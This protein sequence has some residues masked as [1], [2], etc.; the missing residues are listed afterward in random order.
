MK[1]DKNV[2]KSRSASRVQKGFTLVELLVVIAIIAI[3]ATVSVVG[4]TAIMDNVKDKAAM[5]ELDQ[6]QTV[7]RALGVNSEE[8]FSFNGTAMTY[9]ITTDEATTKTNFVKFIQDKCPELKG[10]FT[11]VAAKDST[12]ETLLSISSITYEKDGG[13]VTWTIATGEYSYT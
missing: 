12:N 9:V 11:L 5:Q 6:A 8:G 4:Y 7:L 3:L 1:N 10:T 2:V 13:K